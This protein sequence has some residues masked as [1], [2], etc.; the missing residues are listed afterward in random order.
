MRRCH[1]ASLQAIGI[2]ITI[3]SPR[4]A[5]TFLPELKD[6]FGQMLLL[7]PSGWCAETG[8]DQPGR[9]Q[10]PC[11]CFQAQSGQL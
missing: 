8:E 3:R 11:R 1:F 7:A 5:R 6:L 9:D 10:D 4:I 2:L